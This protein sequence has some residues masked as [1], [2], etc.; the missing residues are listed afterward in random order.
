MLYTVFSTLWRTAILLLCCIQSSQHCGA[1]RYC[2]YAVYRLLNIVGQSD[3]AVMLYTVFSTLWRTA[4]L[5]LCCIQATQHCCAQ[6]YCCYAVYR[7]LNSVA[8]SDIAVMLYTVYSTLWG[9]A[10]L[11]LC[12]IQAAQQR[13]AK[14]YCCYAV[15]RLLSIL[16][17]S[18]IAFIPYTYFSTCRCIIMSNANLLFQRTPLMPTVLSAFGKLRL[19]TTCFVMPVCASVR[20][21][22]RMVELG[23]HRTDFRGISYMSIFWKFV[24]KIQ[25]W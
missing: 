5:L 2:C 13:G 1:Q 7:L 23:S 15:Y 24:E 8:H 25:V 17:H 4:I 22:V 20:P 14:R 10:I 6:R 16:A 9:R 11:L 18:C 19:V 3:I 21:S 12:C